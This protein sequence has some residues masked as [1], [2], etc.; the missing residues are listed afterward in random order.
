MFSPGARRD[1][2]AR[3]KHRRLPHSVF[4][5]Q[6]ATEDQKEDILAWAAAR[7]L[8]LLFQFGVEVMMLAHDVNENLGEEDRDRLLCDIL[9][10]YARDCVERFSST[11]DT[12]GRV[13]GGGV[14]NRFR[15]RLKPVADFLNETPSLDRTSR[16]LLKVANVS[17]SK[18]RSAVSRL[19][20]RASRVVHGELEA[21]RQKTSGMVS[22]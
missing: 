16:M 14:E 15:T 12:C 20:E 13:L 2:E 4:D 18:M 11:N 3:G 21:S 22:Q 1:R 5:W 10:K 19:H 6:V 8:L 9:W 17:A 7:Q